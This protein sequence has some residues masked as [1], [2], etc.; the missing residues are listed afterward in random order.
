VLP[1]LSYAGVFAVVL[2]TAVLAY[3][4]WLRRADGVREDM[5]TRFL[6]AQF[7]RTM[8]LAAGAL[9]LALAVIWAMGVRGRRPLLE[10]IAFVAVVALAVAYALVMARRQRRDR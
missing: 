8:A 7:E 6:P 10:G 1:G 9:A 3:L 4:A 2:A 5:W